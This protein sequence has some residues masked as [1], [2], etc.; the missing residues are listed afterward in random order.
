M[1]KKQISMP[2]IFHIKLALNPTLGQWIALKFSPNS[3]LRGKW[4]FEFPIL[5]LKYCLLVLMAA[6]IFSFW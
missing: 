6:A 2:K 3:F 4:G 5:H 1:G